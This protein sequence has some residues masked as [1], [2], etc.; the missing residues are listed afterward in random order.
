MYTKYS[1][2]KS[3]IPILFGKFEN[4]ANIA[5]PVYVGF[6]NGVFCIISFQLEQIE[7]RKIPVVC[8]PNQDTRRAEAGPFFQPQMGTSGGSRSEIIETNEQHINTQ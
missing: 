8:R 7:P 1:V 6:Q 4:R 5:V 3:N 2:L